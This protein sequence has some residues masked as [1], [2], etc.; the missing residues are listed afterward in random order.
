[1]L[2]ASCWRAMWSLICDICSQ[3]TQEV[4]LR[5]PQG[6]LCKQP[7]CNCPRAVEYLQAFRA[8]VPCDEKLRGL[9]PPSICSQCI[10]ICKTKFAWR[11]AQCRKE[12]SDVCARSGSHTVSQLAKSAK[13]LPV[14]ASAPLH[15]FATVVYNSQLSAVCACPGVESFTALEQANMPCDV[16]LD[17]LFPTARCNACVKYC[18]S[19][20]SYVHASCSKI[21]LK[22]CASA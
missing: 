2:F 8:G 4:L 9:F 6:V 5:L 3:I 14:Q 16:A 11:K 7:V 20:A 13:V 17:G 18:R 10:R 12:D 21:M 19:R 22:L 15:R 1:M